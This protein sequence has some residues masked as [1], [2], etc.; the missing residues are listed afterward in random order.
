MKRVLLLGHPVGHSLSPLFQQA[1]FDHERLAAALRE[2]LKRRKAKAREDVL[3]E[4]AGVPATLVFYET[5]PRL[6][7]SHASRMLNAIRS[8]WVTARS[9]AKTGLGQTHMAG[10]KF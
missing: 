10:R 5:G 7:A 1:A 8:L 3:R 4:L 2:N 9:I 6:V